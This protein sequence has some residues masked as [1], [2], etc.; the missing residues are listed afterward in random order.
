ME[1]VVKPLGGT[2]WI[3]YVDNKRYLDYLADLNHIGSQE[4]TQTINV[5]SAKKE[6]TS[7]ELA[8][9]ILPLGAK[10]K[11]EDSEEEEFLTL[12]KLTGSIFLKSEDGIK[13]Y[14][15]ILKVVHHDNIT[16]AEN[17]LKAGEKDLQA[18]LGVQTTITIS[19]ADLSKAGYSVSPFQLG[20]KIPVKVQS[21]EIDD[22]MLI[23][24][25]KIDL[26]NPESNILTIGRT[27]TSL[28][29]Y[30]AETRASVE[31]MSTQ[32]QQEIQN[33]KQDAIVRVVKETNSNITQS[34]ENVKSEVSTK[35]YNKEQ[36][37][38]LLESIRSMITQTAG[39]IEFNFNQYKKEQATINGD[40]AGKFAEL[41][42]YIR[43][44]GGDIILGQ[45]N[46]PLTLRIENER[47]RFLE[48][49]VSSA[50]W[51]NRK[52]YAVDGEF[53]NQLKLGKFAFIPRSTGN[54][55]FTKVVE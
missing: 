47:I 1:K 42:K 15:E 37:N 34:A 17:L 8:T 9:V 25:L 52:F 45:E 22:K 2:L 38:E 31:T 7:E 28:T 44:V 18:L 50:Y 10:I 29:G 46:N 14:G 32:L 48:N 30:Q 20:T 35:Y 11:K 6:T 21:L 33:A 36:S 16:K 27:L 5:L 19:A 3:R 43:F 41:T 55:T 51:Q 23:N 24:S 26:L 54:L 12:E 53:I 49:G 40:T 13:Q 39:A 4:I